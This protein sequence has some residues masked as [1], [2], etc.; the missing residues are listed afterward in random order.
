[1]KEQDVVKETEAEKQLREEKKLLEAI[2]ENKALMAAK[3]L[4]KGITYTDPITTTWTPPRY[5]LKYPPPRKYLLHY[6][7][8]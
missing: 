8:F 6:L 4:A 1:M 7:V 3:E 2:A 5:V